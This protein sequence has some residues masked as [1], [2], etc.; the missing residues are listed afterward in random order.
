ML[1]QISSCRQL[2]LSQPEHASINATGPILLFRKPGKLIQ[3][4]YIQ[5]RTASKAGVRILK[6]FEDILAAPDACH[7]HA[8]GN[9]ALGHRLADTRCCAY[10][11][12]MLVWERHCFRLVGR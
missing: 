12:D 2:Q 11:E 7:F 3:L 5:R 9:E 10:E 4:C 6:L 8:F 1:H